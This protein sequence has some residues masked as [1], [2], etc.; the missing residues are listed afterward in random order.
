MNIAIDISP[1]EDSGVLS[2]RVR[3]TGFYIEN[4]KKSLLKYYPKNKYSFFIRGEKLSDNINLVHYPYFE[5]FFLTLPFFKKQITAVTVHDLTPLVFKKYFPSGV[6][7]KMKWQIQKMALKSADAIITDSESS[8]KDVIKYTGLP[9]SKIHTVYLAA[10][11]EFK[12]VQSSTLRLRS[13]REFKV[14]SLKE[15]YNLPEKFVLY[16]GDVTWNK[17]LPRLVEAVKQINVT[18]VM[19]GSALVQKKFDPT[20]PWNQDLLKVSKSTEGDKR[21]IKLGFVPIEDLVGIYNLATVFVMPSLYEGFGL[22]ILEAMS[23]GCPVVT[24]KEGSM[25][26]VAGN[27]AYYVNPYDINDIANGIGEVFFSQKLQNELSQKGLK[28]TRKFSW[29]ETARKTT[30]VYEKVATKR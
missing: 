25:P 27:A 30:S 6:R 26:E 24:T 4:L 14:Q 23:C 16:V 9:S 2:H 1:L 8:K 15:K 7:G 20:N 17:N 18:L 28:Q 11:E 22:P 13:G 10:G 19:V 12:Q 21:I 3:G 5:P 29:K